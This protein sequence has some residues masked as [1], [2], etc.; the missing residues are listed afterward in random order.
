MTRNDAI[1]S[2]AKHQLAL[3]IGALGALAVLAACGPIVDGS[4]GGGS[5]PDSGFSQAAHM[6]PVLLTSSGGPILTTPRLLPVIW[7]DDGYVAQLESYAAELGSSP[8]LSQLA[9]YG[10]LSLTATD[11]GLIP[12]PLPATLDDQGIRTALREAIAGYT[13]DG[14]SEASLVQDIFLF[15]VPQ[16]TVFTAKTVTLCEQAGGYHS[17]LKLPDGMPIVYAVAEEC[18]LQPPYPPSALDVATVMISHEVAEAV[19]DPL[20]ED[21]DA[22]DRA[23]PNPAFNHS[24]DYAWELVL[25]AGG[26]V[27]DL[28]GVAG[29][30]GVIV[31]GFLPDGG[32][33]S[34]WPVMIQSQ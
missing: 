32:I 12:G 19:T 28:A 26:E 15:V 8:L 14:G 25:G 2:A 13:A 1:L 20:A 31:E 21:L 9:Q 23:T 7:Q 24:S 27:G 5:A 17:F 30:E 4:D 18:A 29:L 3:R 16:G 6:E 22:S 11:A 34:L 33:S 10:V